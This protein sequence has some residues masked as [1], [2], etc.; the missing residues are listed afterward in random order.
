MTRSPGHREHPEHKVAER[1][2][3][4][5]IKV[6][7]AGE[8]VADSSDV[9]KVEEDGSPVRYY[10]PRA[11]VEMQ[12]LERSATTSQC[13]FKGVANYFS[14]KAGDKEL[15]DAVWSYED[16]YEDHI[17][18]KGRLAFYDDRLPQISISP[19]P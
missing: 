6:S 9:I 7:V 14:I 19:R 12:R 18:L 10:F 17:A 4:E 11:D 16:P 2:L 8:T 3:R 1:Q 13:P 15:K 5:R